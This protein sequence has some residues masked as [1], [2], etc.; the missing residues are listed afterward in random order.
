MARSLKLLYHS[1]L[2]ALNSP[3]PHLT[4]VAIRAKTVS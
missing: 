3:K 4:L 1:G 2:S